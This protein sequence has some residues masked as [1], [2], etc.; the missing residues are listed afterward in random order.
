MLLNLL[1]RVFPQ[2]NDR[3]VVVRPRHQY[4]HS[5]VLHGDRHRR[6]HGTYGISKYVNVH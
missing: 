6:H 4:E 2:E 3:Q 5:A 1:A